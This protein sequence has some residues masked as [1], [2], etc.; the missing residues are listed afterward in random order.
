MNEKKNLFYLYRRALSDIKLEDQYDNMTR[1]CGGNMGHD[2]CSVSE[3]FNAFKLL[4]NPSKF[5]MIQ[6]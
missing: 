6:T 4:N 2:A 5:R 3:D 1:I